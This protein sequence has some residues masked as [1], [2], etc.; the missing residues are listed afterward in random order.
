MGRL[1]FVAFYY[2]IHGSVLVALFGYPVEGFYRP[3][4]WEDVKE[5]PDTRRVQGLHQQLPVTL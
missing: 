4:C 5:G 3:W 1:S 2:L